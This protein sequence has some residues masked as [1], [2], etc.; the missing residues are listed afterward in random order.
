MKEKCGLIGT[1]AADDN[2]KRKRRILTLL[3]V[4]AVGAVLY[5]GRA[6]WNTSFVND[7]FQSVSVAWNFLHGDGLVRN[8]TLGVEKTPYVRGW[9][10]TVLLSLWMWVFGSSEIALRELSALYGVLFLASI[11]YIS[12]R[13]FHST[14]YSVILCI[15]CLAEKYLTIYFGTVR[16]Y[17]LEILMG[18]W[19]YYFTYKALTLHNP[20]MKKRDGFLRSLLDFHWG[21]AAAAGVLLFFSYWNHVNALIPLG[22]C[23][24]FVFYKAFRTGEKRYV[25]ISAMV[26]AAAGLMAALCVIYV[27]MGGE[28]TSQKLGSVF[29]VVTY[30]VSG[31]YPQA[32]YLEYIGEVSGGV[33]ISIAAIVV[34]LW[35]VR[36]EKCCDDRIMYVLLMV[37][38][39]LLFFSFFSA[40]RYLFKNKYILICVPLAIAFYAY[41]YLCLKK[42]H[43]RLAIWLLA[44]CV[45][46]GG[47]SV[48][49]NVRQ[50]YLEENTSDTDFITAYGKIGYYYNLETQTVPV[51]GQMTRAWY[52]EKV[53]PSSAAGNLERECSFDSWRAFAQ[54]Y[55]E[56][57]V[58]CEEI[59][60]HNLSQDVPRIILNWTDRLSG[61]G[62]DNTGVNVSG[63]C[64]LQAKEGIYRGFGGAEESMEDAGQI[65]AVLQGDKVIVQIGSKVISSL[66]ETDDPSFLFVKVDY[67]LD[68]GHSEQ[69]CYQVQLPE[70][71]G[72][73]CYFIVTEDDL[74][75]FMMEQVEN[76]SIKAEFGLYNE[77]VEDNGYVTEY[78]WDDLIKGY[79]CSYYPIAEDSVVNS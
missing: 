60:I 52:F 58:T 2:K 21:Y 56:G 29:A 50:L 65:Q 59:K 32:E 63:Y 27:R 20:W 26:A 74:Y 18:V 23:L 37:V 35:R 15:G 51:I 77:G 69:R 45:L 9:P 19:L 72:S 54:T 8:T 67:T 39:S 49:G 4:C 24:L 70:N 36:K 55:P 7:E 3:I 13:A 33:G 79:Q 12:Y 64:F 10:S 42:Y 1:G 31:F 53:V 43:Q 78:V 47:I 40:G 73:G 28:S 22:G 34:I 75:N 68:D 5:T 25:Y 48:A 71:L 38:F 46:C 16:M 61:T 11:Y 17:S 41:S 44:G 14:G 66:D 57:I 62:I 30:Y 76:V 6:L